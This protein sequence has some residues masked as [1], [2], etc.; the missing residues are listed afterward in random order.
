MLGFRNWAAEGAKAI[1]EPKDK[2]SFATGMQ[3]ALC[4]DHRQTGEKVRRPLGKF[5]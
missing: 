2:W 4:K 1:N 5:F 3:R